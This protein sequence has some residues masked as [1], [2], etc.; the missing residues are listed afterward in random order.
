M[1][2]YDFAEIELGKIPRP[3][4]QEQY[5]GLLNTTLGVVGPAFKGQAFVP[6]II[7]NTLDN[8]L[9]NKFGTNRQNL[10]QHLY[11]E[12]LNYKNSQ[13]Y[14]AANAW[15]SNGGE[16]LYYTRVLGIGSGEK[17]DLTGKMKGS[18][19][20][21]DQ[22]VSF[23]TLDNT[24]SAY[25]FSNNDEAKG[26]VGFVV[27]E[28]SA[29]NYLE[30]NR[31]AEE[32]F[33]RARQL[34][35]YSELGIN[36]AADNYFITNVF[37]FNQGILPSFD[38]NSPT[39]AY[40]LGSLNEN[41]SGEIVS[42]NITV[43]ETNNLDVNVKITGYN[44]LFVEKMHEDSF[45]KFYNGFT[46]ENNTYINEKE[47]SIYADDKNSANCFCTKFFEKG[48]LNYSSF[49][50]FHLR[51]AN[52]ASIS[53]TKILLTRSLTDEE[54]LTHTD[55]NSWES[56]YTVAKTPWVTSQ[57]LDR[58]G[59][60]DVVDG[61][62]Y[63]NR[64][65]IHEKVKD[66]FRFHAL[67]DGEIG[68]RFRIKIN[69][70][71]RGNEEVSDIK[72]FTKSYQN[73]IL[74]NYTYYSTPENGRSLI[75]ELDDYYASFDVYVFE[76]DPRVNKFINLE[77]EVE[78]EVGP[79]A[80]FE[81]LNLNPLSESYIGKV[82]GTK[83]KYY[84]FSADCIV[85]K[86]NFE[87]TNKYIRV[88][89]SNDI[90]NI[91]SEKQHMLLPSGFRSYP[92]IELNK[93]SFNHY[94]DETSTDIF[95]N[96]DF[97]V[98]FDGI[99]HLPPLYNL[100]YLQDYTL[101][102][103]LPIKN[104]WGP[105]F[106]NVKMKNNGNRLQNL[107]AIQG[108]SS[109]NDISEREIS[110]HYYYTKYFLSDCSRDYQNVWKE[111]DNYL[112]SFF[113]LEKIGT[114]YSPAVGSRVVNNQ[115]YF[116][117][118]H[119]GRNL[120]DFQGS[121]SL[122]F[123]INLDDI[124]SDKSVWKD[125]R[126]LNNL[127]AN[128]LSFDMF[129]YGG[130]DGVDI[131]DN[132]KRS[133]TNAS[134]AREAL[135]EDETSIVEGATLNS[136]KKAV[137][138]AYDNAY[139]DVDF[140]VVPDAYNLKIVDECVKL[141]DDSKKTLFIGDARGALDNV[142]TNLFYDNEEEDPANREI[143]NFYVQ[144][145]LNA[146]YYD[147]AS[148]ITTL[149]ER[150]SSNLVIDGIDITGNSEIPL[151]KHNDVDSISYSNVAKSLNK[152]IADQW[153]TQNSQSKYSFIVHGSLDCTTSTNS[154]YMSPVVYTLAQFAKSNK[155]ITESGLLNLSGLDTVNIK[156]IEDIELT[157]GTT[158]NSQDFLY[159][160]SLSK[161]YKLNLLVKKTADATFP[162][163][164][165]QLLSYE[166]N[167]SIFTRQD[168]LR[169][170]LIIKKRVKYD[171]FLNQSLVEGGFLFAQNSNS[172]NLSQLLKIQLETLLSQFVSEGLISDFRVITKSL[173][174]P[175]TIT[176]MQNYILRGTILLKFNTGTNSSIISLGLDS[177]LSDL[178][179]LND[180]NTD[181]VLIPTV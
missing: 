144:T 119:S 6:T 73:K 116:Y 11:D 63:D 83:H 14:L 147:I 44:P 146:N 81:N 34:Q 3:N 164:N 40:E 19:F 92:H 149:Y 15:L 126:S 5:A 167:K 139:S 150:N 21:A 29:G 8:T 45:S 141:S 27:R 33:S 180:S 166:V 32:G 113:H 18:G 93:D 157:K 4:L 117:Y 70:K 94:L 58:S 125:D 161:K 138:I 148:K 36:S 177:I 134:I 72:F 30:T 109:A 78:E 175:E 76:Y 46:L 64:V 98:L 31:L 50:L 131:R 104:S 179:L 56:E 108:P 174:D 23:G 66:L 75:G 38:N 165:T 49:P 120:K 91:T 74:E 178:S 80:T 156:L 52:D 107:D 43:I 17:N 24:R 158:D 89:I 123:Y 160:E 60:V 2:E 51:A 53:K 37:I 151:F 162:T 88:E 105:L 132:D 95:P 163:L 90:E 171:L 54:K 87:N 7:S 9:I 86:G 115:E 59:F 121:N 16:F 96:F 143:V 55:Y 25:R 118:K 129:T 79:V 28:L 85:E 39:N 13:G 124:D 47:T 41:V 35:Y 65:N 12:F 82:I 133:F 62:T 101:P 61:E 130:F 154:F 111:E 168:I 159:L 122:D 176:D 135:G 57:P 42:D 1:A 114:T 153:S 152:Q 77:N 67:D 84:D 170:L 169:N 128:K 137:K 20:R 102:T 71:R 127:F 142:I 99:K 181:A 172:K 145:G 69:I 10:N 68:N 155:S 97:D 140:F 106:F 112:N 110:P 103:G 48:Y 173:D 26:T 22:N 100:C 136:Y